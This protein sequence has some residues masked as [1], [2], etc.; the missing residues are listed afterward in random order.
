[1][2]FVPDYEQKDIILAQNYLKRLKNK[3]NDKDLNPEVEV[4]EKEAFEKVY[5]LFS[6]KVAVT[7]LVGSFISEKGYNI[8]DVI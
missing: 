6:D 4:I 3:Q 8:K 5:K 7:N 1:M 2:P